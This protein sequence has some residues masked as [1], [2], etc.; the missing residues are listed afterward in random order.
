MLVVAVVKLRNCVSA[1]LYN[2]ELIDRLNDQLINCV[3]FPLS[4]HKVKSQ[5]MS[6]GW[7][8]LKMVPQIPLI[9]NVGPCEGCL[10]QVKQFFLR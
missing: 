3:V 2:T 5:A 7:N 8:F 6:C 9:P 4:I 1:L 10:I